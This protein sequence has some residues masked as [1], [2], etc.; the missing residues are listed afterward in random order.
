MR[1]AGKLRDDSP[2]RARLWLPARQAGRLIEE[3]G[4][5]DGEGVVDQDGEL[6]GKGEERNRK[7]GDG[8]KTPKRWKGVRA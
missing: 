6:S 8:V 3:G 1:K 4:E 5:A 2:L 7:E